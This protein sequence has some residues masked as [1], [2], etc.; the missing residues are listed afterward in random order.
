[1]NVKFQLTEDLDYECPVLKISA[2]LPEGMVLTRSG[3]TSQYIPDE[4]DWRKFGINV[5]PMFRLD[6]LLKN[7]NIFKKLI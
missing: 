6:H 7:P 3:F 1:M 5:M 2:T 4:R